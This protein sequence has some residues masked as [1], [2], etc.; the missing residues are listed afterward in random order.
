M[1]PG[2]K[3][4]AINIQRYL[5]WHSPYPSNKNIRVSEFPKSGGTWLCQMIGHLFQI[6]FPRHTWLPFSQ[7]IEHAHYPGPSQKKTIVLVRD[8]R[9][10]FTSA[11]FHF[12]FESDHKPHGLVSYWKKLSGIRNVDKV[13]D[14]MPQFIKTFTEHFKIGGR[15]VSWSDHV[16]SYDYDNENLYLCRYEDLITGAI[17]E[18]EKIGKWANLEPRINVEETVAKF[19]FEELSG[20][21]SGSENRSEFLRKGISGDWKN[22]FS[23][24]ATGIFSKYHGKA[25][26][27][28]GYD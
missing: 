27:H 7:C 21:L 8:G 1:R 9:D 10:V 18:L 20:R 16:M 24:E 2:L 11:Y 12:L 3:N 22:Y 5:W 28:L 23:E 26:K 6:P 15:R 13:E 17:E 14:S 25:M 19:S 4:R